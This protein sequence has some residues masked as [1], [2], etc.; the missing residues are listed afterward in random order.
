PG[1]SLLPSPGPGPGVRPSPARSGCSWP[2]GG[3][4]RRPRRGRRPARRPP[5]GRV[6]STSPPGPSAR[7]RRTPTTADRRGGWTPG[8]VSTP[9]A[10]SAPTPSGAAPAAAPRSR[11]G[12]GCRAP[13]RAGPKP[14]PDRRTAGR[15]RRRA[16]WGEGRGPGRHT[17]QENRCGCYNSGHAHRPPPRPPRHSPPGAVVHRLRADRRPSPPGRCQP[18]GRRGGHARHRRRHVHRRF[19]GPPGVELHHQPEDGQLRRGN[20]GAWGRLLGA[21][22]HAHV[23]HPHRQ[24]RRRQGGGRDPGHGA[25]AVDH[26]DEQRRSGGRRARLP[27]HRRLGRPPRR[28]PTGGP[29]RRRPLRRPLLHAVLGPVQP[30]VLAV[31]GGRRQVPFRRRAAHGSRLHAPL[32]PVRTR[33]IAALVL[34]VGVLP[35]GRVEAAAP[36]VNPVVRWNVAVLDAIRTTATPAT[37]GARALAVAHTCMYDAWTAYD[38]VATGTR[39]GGTLRRPA[40]ERTLEAKDEAI[41]RAA[42][43]ALVD[44]YPALAPRFDAILSADGYAPAAPPAEGTPAGVALRACRAVLDFRHHDGANQLGDEPGG[45]GAPY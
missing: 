41:S 42:R 39:L 29:R 14:G 44:L 20:A 10:R 31:D 7:P 45:S 34:S 4:G 5:G 36:G 33:C 9:A 18:P 37:V 17:Q 2:G 21:L 6:W 28:L 43:L 26:Q 30:H 3:S 23:L 1:R 8:S 32:R 22:R 13:G 27:G 38:P 15:R 16:S 40:D 25:D 35:V 24:L 12:S 19:R 11:A